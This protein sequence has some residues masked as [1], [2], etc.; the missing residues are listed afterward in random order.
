MRRAPI[1]TRP[2]RPAEPARRPRPGR[3]GDRGR[4]AAPAGLPPAGVRGADRPGRGERP[5]GRADRAGRLPPPEHA[6]VAGRGAVRGAC[7]PTTP[8]A[9]W[10][11][12]SPRR[13]DEDCRGS[14]T[15]SRTTD[16]VR[17]MCRAL[18]GS[19]CRSRDTVLVRDGRW[20]SYDCPDPCC[21]SRRRHAAARRRDGAGGRLDRHRHR[22]GRRPR[23]PRRAH[24]PA[25]GPDARRPWRRPAPASG[26]SSPAAVLDIGREARRRG[27]VG[28]RHRRRPRGAGRARPAAR[29]TDAEVARVVWGLRDGEVRD[30][31]LRAG[32]R[33]GAGR[34]RAAVDRVHAAGA[35]HRWTPRPRRCWRS[36]PGCAATA[37]WPTSRSAARSTASPATRLAGLLATR[38]PACVTRRTGLRALL[39]EPAGRG[40]RA[41]R[42][43]WPTAR[44]GR[45][46]G[47][48]QLGALPLLAQDVLG[49][50][51]EHRLVPDHARCRA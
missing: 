15:G 24:R 43:T 45:L 21:D 48:E 6:P 28:G 34:G 1:A 46:A 14:A 38:W 42:L 9:R 13:P 31:A 30:R 50:E 26:W 7:A 17:E 22:G 20:W 36:A 27:L 39:S 33:R 3:R 51:G 10:S 5:P 18:A 44:R 25:A 16:L 37:P 4:A 35:R 2:P 12:W 8:T 41:G 32:A 23:G 11:W 49:Q 47:S 19:A 29:L 40:S